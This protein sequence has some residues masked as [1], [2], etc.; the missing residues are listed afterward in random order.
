[1]KAQRFSLLSTS[2]TNKRLPFRQRLRIYGEK[3]SNSKGLPIQTEA[4]VNPGSW[5]RLAIA[6]PAESLAR[7]GL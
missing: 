4:R 6:S 1:M 5:V 7:S 2:I 3:F